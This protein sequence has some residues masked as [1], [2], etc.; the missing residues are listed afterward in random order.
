MSAHRRI[1]RS[2]TS[3]SRD[4]S[5]VSNHDA[6]DDQLERDVAAAQAIDAQEQLDFTIEQSARTIIAENTQ[7]KEQKSEKKSVKSD[8]KFEKLKCRALRKQRV[9]DKRALETYL[10]TGIIIT[11]RGVI[12]GNPETHRRRKRTKIS[13]TDVSDSENNAD[14]LRIRLNPPFL[15]GA[16]SEQKWRIFINAFNAYWADMPRRI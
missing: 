3:L 9:E 15:Y 7:N 13:E 8:E 10:R 4:K 5:I 14:T 2:Q 11:V 1:L 16:T 6:I 12:Y